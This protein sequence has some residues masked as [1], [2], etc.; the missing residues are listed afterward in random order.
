MSQYHRYRHV[1][2]NDEWQMSSNKVK[3]DGD[4]RV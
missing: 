2:Q 1:A 4:E 3:E